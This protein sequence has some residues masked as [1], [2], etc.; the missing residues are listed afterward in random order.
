[1]ALGTLGGTVANLTTPLLMGFLIDWFDIRIAFAFR[2]AIG[3]AS[4]AA[5]VPLRISAAREAGR[6]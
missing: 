5:L 1:M 2:A 6:S 3:F 4:A